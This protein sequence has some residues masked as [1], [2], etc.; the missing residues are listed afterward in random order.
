V[1]L[2]WDPDAW[3]DYLFWQETDLS[4]LR[5]INALIA[6]IVRD[7][8]QGRGRPEPLWREFDGWWSRRIT[9]EHRLVYRIV[10]TGED[11]SVEIVACRYHYRR[12]PLERSD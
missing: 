7:P 12:P 6:D 10:G 1:R 2:L 4:V 8:F 3:A 9:R 5:D 11:Q